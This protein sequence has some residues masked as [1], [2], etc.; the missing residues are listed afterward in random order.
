MDGGPTRNNA[1]IPP[2]TQEGPMR[3][4]L[5]IAGVV[6]LLAGLF[7]AGQGMGYIPWP[8]SSFM[9]SN[10]HWVYYG[11]GIAAAGLLLVILA[12]TRRG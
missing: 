8:R 1:I 5:L 11:A 10:F 7:F 3:A 9:V 4:L 6:V 12:G 2:Q